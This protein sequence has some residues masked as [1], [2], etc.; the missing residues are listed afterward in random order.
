MLVVSLVEV[1]VDEMVVTKAERRAD[2]KDVLMVELKV[3]Y[4]VA[5]MVDWS[6]D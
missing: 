5:Q 4:S 3:L 2:K 1:R 6:A